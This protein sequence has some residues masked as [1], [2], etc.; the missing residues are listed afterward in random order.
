MGEDK[1]TGY[2]E[3]FLKGWDK[4]E[5]N[6]IEMIEETTMYVGTN[7]NGIDRKE[8]LRKIEQSKTDSYFTGSGKQ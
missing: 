2:S 1:V 5:K 8:L 6:I 7:N 4:C 3:G